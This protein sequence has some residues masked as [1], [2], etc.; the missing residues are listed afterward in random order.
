MEILYA[1]LIILAVFIVITL[2]R[3]AFYVPKKNGY[4]PLPKEN[5]DTER[6]AKHLSGAIQIPTVSYPDHDL[7]D[8]AQFEKFHKYL[9]D[10]Y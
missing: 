9:E 5:V 7:V 3:A 8:W 10:S 6:V 4:E 1:I 2:I